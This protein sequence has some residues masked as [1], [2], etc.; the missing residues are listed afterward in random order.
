M[1]IDNPLIR[2]EIENFKKVRAVAFDVN[3]SGLTIIHG[4]N[5]QGKSSTLKAVATCLNGA[6]PK[7]DL[8][9]REG[10]THSKTV[11]TF[12][13][14]TIKQLITKKG[15][16]F[17]HEMKVEA[18]D[19]FSPPNAKS[20]LKGLRASSADPEK[21]ARASSSEQLKT[22]LQVMNLDDKLKA[23]EEDVEK[24]YDD[25][26]E[27]GREL[28]RLS[29]NADALA[30]KLRLLPL[31]P[32]GAIENAREEYSRGRD[33]IHAHAVAS[34]ELDDTKET[35]DACL[36]AIAKTKAKLKALEEDRL[37]L[38]DLV[39]MKERD[40]SEF[41]EL[42]D[43]DELEAKL[44]EA[45]ERDRKRLV[46]TSLEA[47]HD[48][49]YKEYCKAEEAHGELEDTLG[50]RRQAVT[51]LLESATFPIEGMGYDPENKWLTMDGIPFSQCSQSETARISAAV[52]M[53]GDPPLR[54]LFVEEGSGFDDDSRR[55]LHEQ[56]V[57][58]GFAVI[59]ESVYLGNNADEVEAV[60]IV[61]GSVAL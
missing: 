3:P 28:K 12:K 43:P 5:G 57:E 8:P 21:F 52:A 56:A 41:G 13:E 30:K 49:A 50:E 2:V 29:A 15:D 60:E 58:A 9:V 25:R 27:S 14:F 23:L 37:M 31:P 11:C 6:K 61:D 16:G 36:V 26:T 34:R 45:I 35:Q 44:G 54:V 4:K 55:A 19:G 48:E 51:D 40:L 47:E 32:E 42:P 38:S 53:A 18:A 33:K 1:K 17:K 7:I 20:F 22:V 39:A 46:W 59:L 24:V 10:E